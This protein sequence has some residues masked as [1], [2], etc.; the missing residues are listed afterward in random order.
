MIKRLIPP[1]VLLGILIHHPFAFATDTS[2]EDPSEVSA[3]QSQ[4]DDDVD[5]GAED[6]QSHESK[7]EAQR[8]K[9]NHSTVGG[10]TPAV[11]PAPVVTPS[12]EEIESLEVRSRRRR[13]TESEFEGGFRI[14]EKMLDT[15]EY[16]DIHRILSAAPGVYYREEDG[17]GLRPNIGMRGVSSDRSKKIVIMEDGVLLAP[18]PYAAPAGYYFPLTTRLG[19]VEIYKGPSMLPYGPNTLGGAI[20]LVTAPMPF[21]AQAELDL[22]LGADSFRRLHGR[23]GH[24]GEQWSYLLDFAHL[25]TVG[26][27]NIDGGGESGYV[28]NDLLLKVRWDS[29]PAGNTLH[30]LNLKLGYGDETSDETYLG[31]TQEDYNETPLRRYRG[32]YLDQ[33]EWDR[34]QV[35]LDY[36]VEFESGLELT[37]TGYRHDFYRV[38]EKANGFWGDNS[39]YV[40]GDDG[41]G[42]KSLSL[43]EIFGRPEAYPAYMAVLRGE[44]PSGT[45]VQAA[46]DE[47]WANPDLLLIGR[48]ARTYYSQGIQLN[49]R[50]LVPLG[51]FDHDLRFGAR[52]HQDSV[53]RDETEAPLFMNEAGILNSVGVPGRTYGDNT[54]T[55]N[56]LSAFLYDVLDWYDFSFILGSRV[57]YVQMS[58]TNR[59]DDSENQNTDLVILPGAG[60]TWSMVPTLSLDIGIHRGY[61]PVSPGQDDSTK[62][63]S[64]T[65]YEAALKYEEG[66]LFSEVLVFLSDYS[67]LVGQ[68]GQSGGA[69]AG[70]ADIQYN[71]GSAQIMGLEVAYGYAP[72]LPFQLKLPT[73]LAYTFTD[74]R[75]VEPTDNTDPLYG[76]AER[77]DYLPY[78]PVHQLSANLGLEHERASL[79]LSLGH[80]SAMRDAPGQEPLGEVLSTTSRWVLDLAASVHL[81]PG[82]T[83]YLKGDNITNQSYIVSHRP[84]GIRPGKPMRWYVGL[85]GSYN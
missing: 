27:K 85:K 1:S 28:R 80:Q 33:M 51:E 69:Q 14:G 13:D 70:E 8:G 3:S 56:A 58:R 32:S 55:A 38:W 49:G 23:V 47:P 73:S 42:T 66:G 4:S 17:Y 41:Y 68:A 18:A 22:E 19:A 65:L 40:P 29:D 63:G 81:Y 53:R 20:N 37:F 61:S 72:S 25:E 12:A 64:S 7:D 71:A 52:L 77:G 45:I 57:E 26:F 11:A 46:S 6:E 59:L 21:D 82:L 31:L 10:T 50:W 39:L 67:N 79:V 60:V 48:N 75:F 9:T 36:S 2:T 24:G 78:V 16:D 34:T 83:A 76:G 30:R 74:A 35:Q 54:D 15:F 43:G 62:P 44:A 5:G 84:Y